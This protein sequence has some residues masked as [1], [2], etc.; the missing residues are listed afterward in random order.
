MSKII[1]IDKL[2]EKYIKDFVY[3]NIGKVDPDDI[4]KEIPRLYEKFGDEKLEE[5]SGKT[6]NT[7]YND[8]SSNELCKLIKEH[9]EKGVSVS[10]F[11]CE[12]LVNKEDA[13]GELIKSL[14]NEENEE[15]VMYALN[16]IKDIDK[17]ENYKQ[18][19]DFILWDYSEAVSELATEIIG[20]NA[21]KVKDEILENIDQIKEEK[22]IYLTELLSKCKKDDKV[23]DKLI[24]EFFKHK[25]S[26]AIYTQFLE[27]YGDERAIPFLKEMAKSETTDYADFQELRFA[28]ENLGGECD[29][30]RDFSQDKTYKKIRGIAE[31]SIDEIK[32]NL[33]S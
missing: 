8:L 6:P 26:I 9:I 21:E 5:L 12:S 19:L 13:N 15:Y 31:K 14:F 23:F 17:I 10:D 33:E 27:K 4:E 2:F 29:V 24:S 3:S 28:I 22:K 18:I 32:N 7:F 11:L 16:M 30:K 20:E 1:D 25:E